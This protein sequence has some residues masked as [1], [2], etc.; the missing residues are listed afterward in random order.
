[1]PH[2]TLGFWS[3]AGALPD[4]E[5]LGATSQREDAL[6]DERI[7]EHQVGTPQPQERLPRQQLGITG[8]G[9]DQ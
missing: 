7:V 6:I 3:S 5:T 8:P 1:M 4:K 9:T 2:P